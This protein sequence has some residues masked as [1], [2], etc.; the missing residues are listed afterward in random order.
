MLLIL[1]V[2]SAVSGCMKSDTPS[3]AMP[4]PLGNTRIPKRKLILGVIF[5]PQI[6]GSE[7]EEEDK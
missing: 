6:P 7:H 4:A 5:L 2:I 1:T 3:R